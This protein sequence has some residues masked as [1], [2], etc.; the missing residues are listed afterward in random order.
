M[1]T[2]RVRGV[3]EIGNDD[4]AS[5]VNFRTFPGRIGARERLTLQSDVPGLELRFD[6]KRTSEFLDAQLKGPVKAS[7]TRRVWTLQAE[8]RKGIVRGPFPRRGDPNY[9]DSAIYLEV[10][11]PGKPPRPI[12]IPA[13]GTANEG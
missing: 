7:E 2:G 3:V 8:A 9:E 10:L 6:R 11:V 5:G 13:Q 1:V 12:R 4:N